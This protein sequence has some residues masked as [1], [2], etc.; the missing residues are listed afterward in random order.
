MQSGLKI[1]IM[2]RSISI[3]LSIL[4][5][6]LGSSALYSQAGNFHSVEA[7]DGDGVYSLLR[8]YKLLSPSC[9]IQ[10]FYELN[11]IS[12]DAIL[13][14]GKEYMLPV[15]IYTYN[16]RSIRSTL[17]FDDWKK[18]VRIKEYNEYLKKNKLRKTHYT[19]SKILWVPY[20]E[21]ECRTEKG[22]KLKPQ[23]SETNSDT[24]TEA[25]SKTEKKAGQKYIVEPLFGKDFENVEI[26][27]E[28]LKNKVYYVVAGHGGPDPG[29][30][31]TK[32]SNT[33][34]EDE[35]AYDVTLRLARNLMQH[36]ATVHVVI[37]DKNDGIRTTH[38]LSCDKDEVC[39]NNQQIPL[40]QKKRLFQRS[41]AINQLY[42]HYKS[43]GMK[44]QMAIMIH[45][46]SRGQGKEQDVFFYHFGP[47]KSGK[48]LANNLKDTFK[49]K[50]EKYQK[51]RGYKGHVSA[52]NLYVLRNTL[53][54]AAFV[55][56]ANIQNPNDRERITKPSN[57]Q[58]LANWLFEGMT[59][60]E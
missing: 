26:Q 43:K 38:Y 30:R 21:M 20:G 1:F 46:D 40:D 16:G 34:C 22:K 14:K 8:R 52:R 56:L 13:V 53:P 51:G 5:F 32:C 12:K 41:D 28:R 25:I 27:D 18:A 24:V 48:A 37:Q 55:E 58:A 39:M 15:Q 35:Y 57:R 19:S 7:Q 33:L 9:N 47:S 50:Y 10:K 42:K 6:V 60:I 59:G 31:C 11:S 4:F 3:A 54:T 29:A 2:N 23:N 17:G 36:G 45:I 44:D 49:K